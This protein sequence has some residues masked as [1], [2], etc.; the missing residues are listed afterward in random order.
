MEMDV[1][2]VGSEDVVVVA[3]VAVSSKNVVCLLQT[4]ALLFGNV[5]ISSVLMTPTH[6]LVASLKP[7]PGFGS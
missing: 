4:T 5:E 2:V 1:E 6:G 3:F 7:D